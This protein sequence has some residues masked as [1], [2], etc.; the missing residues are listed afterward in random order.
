MFA[1]RHPNIIGLYAWVLNSVHIEQFGIVME[2]AAGDLRNQY[3][4]KDG[5][6]YSFPIGLKIVI[7]AALGLAHMHTMPEPMIH[8]DIKSMNIMVMPDGETGKLGD[9]GESRRVVSLWMDVETICRL[10]TNKAYANLSQSIGP[11]LNHDEDGH[12]A[13]GRA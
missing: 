2:L 7:G 6:E 12:A 11:H 8:R 1:L 13:L 3:Q 9:C 4:Q 10:K 5:R